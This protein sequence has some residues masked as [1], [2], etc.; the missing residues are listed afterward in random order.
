LGVIHTGLA[1][2]ILFAGMARLT[3]GKIALLQF[4]YPLAAALFDWGVYGTQLSIV[5]TAGV[6]L[7]G[8]AVWTIRKPSR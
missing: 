7:M 6:S 1:Y 8:L 2:V 3:L 4:V 5:Q